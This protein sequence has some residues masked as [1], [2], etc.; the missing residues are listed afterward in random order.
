R[1]STLVIRNSVINDTGEYECVARN[2]LGEVRQ[3][4]PLTVTYP[5]KVPC[6]R[7]T[8]CLNGGSCFHIPALEVDIC[9]CRADYE[10]ARCEKRQP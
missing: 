4:K 1:Q 5:H 8:Y 6:E 7:H 3:S 10:G 2:L 9:E